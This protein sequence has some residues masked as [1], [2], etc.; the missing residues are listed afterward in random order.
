MYPSRNDTGKKHA[1]A[2]VLHWSR[3]KHTVFEADHY[4][5]SNQVDDDA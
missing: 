3:P 4:Y 2:Q 5:T 1:A